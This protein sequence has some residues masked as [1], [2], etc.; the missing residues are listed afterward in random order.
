MVV[1]MF[2]SRDSVKENVYVQYR[3]SFLCINCIYLIIYLFLYA[4]LGIKPMTSCR[5]GKH[6][7][8][9]IIISPFFNI[10]KLRLV[11]S[12][13]VELIISMRII[14]GENWL[15]IYFIHVGL[16][17]L[18]AQEGFFLFQK[19]IYNVKMPFFKYEDGNN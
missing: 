8:T 18:P 17:T 15:Y 2:C 3:C 6:S 14:H 5:L 10:F 4:V 11:E 19:C 12:T 9:E 1:I 13:D 16:L 7:T